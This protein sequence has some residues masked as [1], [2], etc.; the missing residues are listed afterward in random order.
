MKNSSSSS[1]LSRPSSSRSR[2]GTPKNRSRSKPHENHEFILWIPEPLDDL[3]NI[4]QSKQRTLDL[5]NY[6]TETLDKEIQDQLL[7][8]DRHISELNR[9]ILDLKSS[10]KSKDSARGGEKNLEKELDD[11][12][13]IISEL[14]KENSELSEKLSRYEEDYEQKLR[15]WE[16]EKENLEILNNALEEE[17]EGL[18]GSIEAKEVEIGDLITGITTLQ[19]AVDKYTRLNSELLGN[20]DK[21]NNEIK[22]LNTKLYEANIKAAKANELER[23]IQDYI[24]QNYEKEVKNSRLMMYPDVLNRYL[25]VTEWV[26]QNLANVEEHAKLREETISKVTEEN[27]Q[28]ELLDIKIFISDIITNISTIRASLKNS[29]PSISP[30]DRTTEDILRQKLID[31]EKEFNQL[32]KDASEARGKQQAY[33]EAIESLRSTQDR[34]SFDF[35]NSMSKM[36]SQIEI[37]KDSTDKTNARIEKLVIENE[38]NLSEIYSLKSKLAHLNGKQEHFVKKRKEFQDMEEQ[39]RNE[40]SQLKTKLN[41]ADPNRN[42][43]RKNT[44]AEE[45]R[46]KKAMSQLQILR[47]ELFRKDTDLV[48]KAREMIKMEKEMEKE[49]SNNQ[50]MHGRM[51]TIEAEIIAKVSQ[52]LEEKDRQIEILKEMLRCAHSDIKLKDTQLN[53]IRG[54]RMTSP[55]RK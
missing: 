25:K 13:K 15:K 3:E 46:I 28:K 21:V 43:M 36:K 6:Q 29:A 53:N 14:K 18:K 12:E 38:K 23:T 42:A 52:D 1:N 39:L 26:L 7:A 20:V 17:S 32:N 22:G 55:K 37:L 45:M 8:R 41:R 19:T 30:E 5:L 48:R 31:L 34:A 51:K 16:E 10:A 33:I 9:Q 4:I 35:Q 2:Q 27:I 11:Q 24:N 54:D 47:D 50:K 40:I 49:R 44:T